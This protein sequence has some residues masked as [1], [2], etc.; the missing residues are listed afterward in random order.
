MTKRILNCLVLLFFLAL[1][2]FAEG[3]RI[4]T[5]EPPVAYT[6]CHGMV[7]GPDEETLIIQDNNIFKTEEEK[8]A[9]TK[10]YEGLEVCSTAQ[11]FD[12]T[13]LAY[14]LTGKLVRFYDFGFIPMPSIQ[15]HSEDLYWVQSVG[16]DEPH[17]LVDFRNGKV[18]IGDFNF[19]EDY[20]TEDPDFFRDVL[21]D[22]TKLRRVGYAESWH[23]LWGPVGMCPS[24]WR[25]GVMVQ[26]RDGWSFV[27]E[28]G[29]EQYYRV[30]SQYI[31][32]MNDNAYFLSLGYPGHPAIWEIRPDNKVRV[33]KAFPKGYG[34]FPA[35]KD[36][37][38]YPGLKGFGKYY[39]FLAGLQMPVGVFAGNHGL[40]WVL[41]REVTEGSQPSYTLWGINVNQD[42]I[43]K[44][45]HLPILPPNR[46]TYLE[47]VP[48]EKYWAFLL[49][50]RLEGIGRYV[51]GGL[52]TVLL[53]P[54]EEIEG[55]QRSSKLPMNISTERGQK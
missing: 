46:N 10:K 21:P 53:I 36:I 44:E 18:V 2:G 42:R 9:F 25:T 34:N 35:D 14:D 7:W 8:E 40:L 26:T 22:P 49:K 20:D 29:G 11:L 55:N 16:E 47:V 54:A 15:H 28:L 19:P 24:N 30:L 32:A 52:D 4:I 12:R 17:H 1:P 37:P 6:C 50:G 3:S 45:Y 13:I 31:T 48:G 23:F 51:D 43:E 27:G 39:D 38:S 41:T 5:L 33:L